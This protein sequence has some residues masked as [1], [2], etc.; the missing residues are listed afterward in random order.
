MKEDARFNPPNIVPPYLFSAKYTAVYMAKNMN[1]KILPSIS[2]GQNIEAI[3]E[4]DSQWWHDCK[5][6]GLV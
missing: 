1:N 6:V 4:L 2:A 5:P 3:R